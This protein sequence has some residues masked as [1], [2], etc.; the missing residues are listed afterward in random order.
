MPSWR[1]TN[2][3][4][5]FPNKAVFRSST[6]SNKAVRRQRRPRQ[7]GAGLDVRYGFR[8]SGWR[9]GGGRRKKRRVESWCFLFCFMCRLEIGW[10]YP[11]VKIGWRENRCR[12]GARRLNRHT[13]HKT[14]SLSSC[15]KPP[16]SQSQ[17]R[18]Q[19]VKNLFIHRNQQRASQIHNA[20]DK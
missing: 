17:D 2:G 12:Y 20:H 8:I 13:L 6:I 15:F 1:G 9:R 5:M 4:D 10:K 16:T 18:E 14:A 3:R 7:S 19:R 11:V